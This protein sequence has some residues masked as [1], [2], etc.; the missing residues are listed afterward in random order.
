MHC[1]RYLVGQPLPAIGIALVGKQVKCALQGFL[2]LTKPPAGSE[3]HNITKCVK[4]DALLIL[5]LLLSLTPP[6]SLSDLKVICDGSVPHSHCHTL[7]VGQLK[8]NRNDQQNHSR[9]TH[10]YQTDYD[11]RTQ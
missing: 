7:V 2:T 5:L 3:F 8:Q 9:N 11:E 1:V 4:H 6:N 10:N